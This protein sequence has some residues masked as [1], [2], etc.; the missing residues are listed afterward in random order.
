MNITDNA[1]DINFNEKSALVILVSDNI[2]F[3][4]LSATNIEYNK[5]IC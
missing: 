4:N 2:I 1:H 3:R 5:W